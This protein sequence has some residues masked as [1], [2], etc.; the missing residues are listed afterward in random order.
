MVLAVDTT[1]VDPAEAIESYVEGSTDTGSEAGFPWVAAAG[2]LLLV[3][4]AAVVVVVLLR[5]RA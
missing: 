3:M 2:L 4:V 5:R 1:E